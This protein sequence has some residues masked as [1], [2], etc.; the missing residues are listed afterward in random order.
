M[1]KKIIRLNENDLIRLVKKVRKVIREQQEMDMEMD[2]EKRD[3]PFQEMDENFAQ[4]ANCSADEVSEF[5]SSLPNSVSFV[6]IRNCEFAD[7]DGF[8]GEDYP[9]L[10]AV[11]LKG[12]ENNFEESVQN[13]E[14]EQMPSNGLYLIQNWME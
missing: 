2:V 1:A 13:L 7:F 3:E 4:I 6:A 5:L 11:N 9:E 12:T 10:K 14:Y 8:N